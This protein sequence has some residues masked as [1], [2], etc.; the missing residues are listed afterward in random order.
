MSSEAR[1]SQVPSEDA[2]EIS[3]LM[4]GMT[5]SAD[6]G[7]GGRSWLWNITRNI[8][9]IIFANR[10]NS[11]V[12]FCFF[13]E[14]SIFTFPTHPKPLSPLDDMMSGM[15]LTSGPEEDP[16]TVPTPTESP[17]GGGRGK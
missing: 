5:I 2:A 16:Y 8:I 4:N 10:V 6:A 15:E 3:G 11:G 9:P 12:F 13:H 7:G 14:F 1:A 17:T